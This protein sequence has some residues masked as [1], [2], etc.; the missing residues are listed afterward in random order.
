M[1]D[2]ALTSARFG[3]VDALREALE[4]LDGAEKGVLVNFVQPETLNT[5][6]HMG[7]RR[8]WLELPLWILAADERTCGC[9][10]RERTRRLRQGADRE[11]REPPAERERKHA[12]AYVCLWMEVEEGRGADCAA[13]WAVQNK[14]LEVVKL[15]LQGIPDIDVLTQNS[16]GRGCVTEAFQCEDTEIRAWTFLLT[17]YWHATHHTIGAE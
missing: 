13:D 15:L 2:A 11:R 5:P 6:L 12:S 9:S 16:F 7:A 4:A 10:L 3:D 17:N 1:A 8:G 14:H